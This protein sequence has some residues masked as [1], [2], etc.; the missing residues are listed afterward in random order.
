MPQSLVRNLIHVVFSTKNR[1]DMITPEIEDGLFGYIHGIVENNN[2]KLIIVN[3]TSNHVH[4]LISIGKVMSLSELIGDIKRDSSVW[5]KKQ[6]V[7]F[8]N[9]YWQEGYGAF[10]VGQT[11]DEVVIKYIANQKEHHK[12]K[13]YKTE[14]RGFLK[15]Y[16]IEYEERYVWD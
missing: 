6:N 7:N 9:F 2:S 4:L 1:V 11:E 12:T 5:I 15:K 8:N 13:D 14:F 3:G 10:S 16:K